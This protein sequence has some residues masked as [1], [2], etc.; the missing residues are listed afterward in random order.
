[1][2]ISDKAKAS[3]RKS[4]DNE[5]IYLHMPYANWLVCIC[6]FVCI[7]RIVCPTIFNTST[8]SW[9]LKFLTLSNIFS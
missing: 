1:M 7:F 2:S 8:D 3:D 5:V 4:K 6:L 9:K